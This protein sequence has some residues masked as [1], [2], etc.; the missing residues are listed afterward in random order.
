MSFP[1]IFGYGAGVLI[2]IQILVEYFHLAISNYMNDKKLQQMEVV[3]SSCTMG[4]TSI[5][6][7]HNRV[8]KWNFIIFNFA[9]FRQ[10][11]NT[12]YEADVILDSHKK[13]FSPICARSKN[14]KF[15]LLN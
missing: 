3:W 9:L 7:L 6:Q 8:V 2:V 1:Y 5:P 4:S 13:K 12:K 10:V 15:P 11:M 14:L